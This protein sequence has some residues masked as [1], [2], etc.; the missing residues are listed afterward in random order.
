MWTGTCR[1]Q[2]GDVLE[3]LPQ[4]KIG[5]FNQIQEWDEDYGE[6][7]PGHRHISHLFALH[8]GNQIS[9]DKT[10]ELANAA[11]TTLERRLAHGGGHTGWSRAWII[12]FWARLQ[13]GEQAYV[14]TL[15]TLKQSTLDNLFS[16]HPPF[17]IDG[18][19]G[20]TAGIAE[21]LLQSHSGAIRLLPALPK[22]WPEGYVKGLRARGGFEFD[23]HWRDRKLVESRVQSVLGK[24]CLIYSEE[25]LA[26][27][28]HGQQ[29]EVVRD[30]NIIRFNTEQGKC[31][32]IRPGRR[33]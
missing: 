14:N 29:V 12:N 6:A 19:F 25:E 4:P 23:L 22:V 5:R 21:M 16:N 7:E 27:F 24:Q 9:V 28:S 2:F 17:Q 18:K 32:Q 20:G 15:E 31:Y 26:V 33:G 1:S 3:R 11:R 30:G 8:P 13:D 10:P